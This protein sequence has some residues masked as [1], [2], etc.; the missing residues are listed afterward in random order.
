MAT[1]YDLC[2]VFAAIDAGSRP[3]LRWL[4]ESTASKKKKSAPEKK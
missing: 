3:Y 4:G 1:Q 2:F